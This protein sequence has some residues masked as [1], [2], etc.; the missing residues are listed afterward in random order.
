MKRVMLV[1]L[2]MLLLSF[3]SAG[4]GYTNVDGPV[5]LPELQTFNNNTAFVNSTRWWNTVTLGPM[6]DANFAQFTNVGGTLTVDETH[7]NLLYCQLTGC[8][9]SGDIN[10][11]N[12][13]L[14][15][16]G[17]MDFD[18][19]ATP[20]HEEG[21]LHWD[22][23]AGTLELGLRG[24]EVKLQI[25][26]EVVLP[27]G[28]ATG[29]DIDNGQ[30]VY[31]SGASGS[32]PELTLAKADSPLTSSATIAVA[33][34]DIIENNN[35]YYTALG[36]VRDIPVPTAT[37]TDGDTLYLS[38]TLAGAFTNVK[39][40]QPNLIIKVGYVMR[41]H[42]TEGIIFVNIVQRTNNF[43]HIRGL[44][45][46]SIPF[47]N[48]NGFLDE[49]NSNLF[50]DDT[51]KRLG[52]GTDSPTQKLEIHQSADN[53]GI[54]LYG[55]DDKSSD[56][57]EY[58]VTND[59]SAR[60]KSTQFMEFETLNS[61][62]AFKSK[63]NIYMNLGDH[64]GTYGLRVRDDSFNEIFTVESNGNVGIGTDSPQNK[65][66]VAGAQVIG[67]SYA[68]VNTAPTDGLLVEG[69]VGIGISPIGGAKVTITKDGLA[70][71]ALLRLRLSNDRDWI[72]KEV[73]TGGG[74]LELL[75]SSS[76]DFFLKTTAW[77]FEQPSHPNYGM[78][79]TP[80]SST[81][82]RGGSLTAHSSFDYFFKMDNTGTGNYILT[83]DKI[84]IGTDSPGAELE[85]NGGINQTEGNAT[86]NMIY[87]E[88]WGKEIGDVNIISQGVYYNVTNVSLGETNGFTEA[89]GKLTAK[90]SGIYSVNSAWSFS[91]SANTEY[92]L[93][94]GV[95]GGRQ[96]HCHAQ[97]KI[98][99]GGDVGSSSLSCIDRFN[100]GDVITLM[101]ENVDSA[102]D[103]TIHSIN[104][105]VV[106]IGN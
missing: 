47:A 26:Q 55:Y 106:R 4:F 94:L 44:T 66:D 3:A 8:D 77:I 19:T 15:D 10:M 74:A 73:D 53:N 72:F 100:A 59:G 78:F 29:S 17:Y 90:Y 65:L 87:G 86:I 56:Y 21:R 24:G 64:I 42:D 68:G 102:T 50:W 52:I 23:D 63:N 79:F 101:I 7:F 9:M 62:I 31:I 33:T 51:N 80:G 39:P 60:F 13:A 20:T 70:G 25:G 54:R 89:D 82:F 99:T 18:L 12:N 69:D 75:S 98:G 2:S 93:A 91:G 16:I 71:D 61:Y 28:K 45:A 43:E 38:A 58:F 57:A 84:G 41:A 85:V 83:A 97:R 92:H 36:L 35:G 40:V 22:D 48:A 30:V 103:P 76:K 27:R 14:T 32:K 5:L 37:Y 95:N 11:T 49:N 1:A 81:T 105:N 67:S 88:V 46:G 104:L 96:E 34:E 6:D